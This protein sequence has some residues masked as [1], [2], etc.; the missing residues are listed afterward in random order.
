MK[1]LTPLILLLALAALVLPAV[2]AADPAATA[3]FDRSID[4]LFAKHYPQD[5]EA[6][7]SSLGTNPLL[8]FRWAGTSAE[9]AVSMRVLKAFRADGLRSVRLEPVPVDVFEFKSATLRVGMRKMIGS[10]FGG[11]P[12]TAKMGIAA[13]IVYVHG[14]TASDFDAAESAYGPVA[15]KLV[16]MDKMMTSWW[17]NMPAFEAGLRGAA[18]VIVTFTPEDPKY[19][20]IAPDA[21]GSF[22]G[23]YDES[24]P[25]LIYISQVDGDWLKAKLPVE[26]TMK[27]D[28]DVRMAEDGGTGYNVVAVL[29]G[30][31]RDGQFTL[32]A[33]HQDA[34]FRAGLDDTGALVNML[35]IAKAM[36]I[37]GYRPVHDVVFLAT[38]GEEFAYT[39]A[40]YE[41]CV[42]A[43]Y[44]ATHTHKDW[45]GHIRAM[46]NLELMALKDAPLEFTASPELKPWLE[47]LTAANP[48]LTPNGTGTGVSIPVNSWNDQWTFTAAGAPSV[49]F[50]TSNERYT[51]LYHS[52]YEE[53]SLI[54]WAYMADIAKLVFRAQKSIDTGVL[55]YSLKTRADHLAE[56][57]SADELL[58]AGADPA[59]VTRLTTAMTAFDAAAISLQDNAAGLSPASANPVLLRVEKKINRGMTALTPWDVTIY[60]HQQVM[61]DVEGMNAAIAALS[62]DPVDADAAFTALS[63]TYLTWYGMNFSYPVFLQELTRRDPA[64][65]RINWG[66]QGHLP[67]PLDVMPEWR[68]IGTGDYAG[69]ISGLKTE[70]DFYLSDLNVRLGDMARVLEKV[71]PQIEALMP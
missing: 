41:W 68:Q 49:E 70:R 67:K 33:A 9:K 5:F 14:G 11:V 44:A 58:T 1:R 60:P 24:A 22:D 27:L 3:K 17:Y 32:I 35:A 10:T 26:G 36:R 51:T 48:D 62:A 57:V 19:Y 15:G 7:F 28:I 31:V 45:S 63:G 55:P 69:A 42:G 43:W 4:K 20:S 65:Y 64:Y 34:H 39:N 46:L 71:T 8:G 47:G 6:Y 54:D 38:T 50:A 56:N 18:G 37:S 53:M 12:P 30:R 25:P 59:A 40:Y 23:Y 16:L 66:G 21:L 13:D 61:W 29:P 2:A 52:N